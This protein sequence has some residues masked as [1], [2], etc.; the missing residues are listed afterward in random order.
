MQSRVWRWR[1]RMEGR[2]DAGMREEWVELANGEWKEAGKGENEDRMLKENF[3]R[4]PGGI[5]G[6]ITWWTNIADINLS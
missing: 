6:N 2:R 3:A 1:R 4:S 5:T